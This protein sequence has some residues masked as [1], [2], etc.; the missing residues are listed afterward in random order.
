MIVLFSFFNIFDTIETF[1]T[2]PN[3][4]KRYIF[5]SKFL[6]RLY[7]LR[8]FIQKESSTARKLS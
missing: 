1:I 7:V 5:Y 8:A 6:E 4:F 3:Y 2:C